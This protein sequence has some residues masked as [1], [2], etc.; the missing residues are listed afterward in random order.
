MGWGPDGVKRD[1][2]S[3]PRAARPGASIGRMFALLQL[4]AERIARL[5]RR[6]RS[7]SAERR[8][9]APDH[10]WSLVCDPSLWM[11]WMPRVEGLIDGPARP[12]SG[13]RYRVALG[14]PGTRLGLG[15][16]REGYVQLEDYEPA[17]R[18]AWQLIVGAG[19]QRYALR[20]TGALLHCEAEGGEDPARVLAELDR[21]TTPFER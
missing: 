4:L 16:D 8:M 3:D 19:V 5:G 11:L 7:G 17:E 6:R 21:E 10:A 13:A 9:Q 14:A 18:V 2:A 15:S 20:R 1:P 12:R